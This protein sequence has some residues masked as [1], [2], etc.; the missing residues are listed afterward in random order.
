MVY[1]RQPE[2]RPNYDPNKLT[3][4]GMDGAYLAHARQRSGSQPG[5]CDDQ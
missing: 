3:L 1:E 2:V 4:D 5:A